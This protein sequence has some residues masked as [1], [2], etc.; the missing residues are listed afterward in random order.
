MNIGFI[1][2]VVWITIIKRICVFCLIYPWS[3]CSGGVEVRRGIDASATELLDEKKLSLVV[4]IILV[5]EARTM[6]VLVFGEIEECGE[7]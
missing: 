2:D 1:I 5:S 4:E 6:E 7:V 3:P